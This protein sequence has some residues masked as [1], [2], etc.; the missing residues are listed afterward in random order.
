MIR[1]APSAAA[2]IDDAIAVSFDR[3]ESRAASLGTSATALVRAARRASDGGK[4]FRPALV[5]ASF[6]AFGGDTA[7]TPAIWQVAAA[8]EILHTAFVIHDDVIDRDTE[9]RG[10]LNVVGEFRERGRE[11]GA[12]QAGAAQLGEAAAILAGDLLLHEASRIIATAAL[13]PLQRVE[14]FGLLDDAILVSAVGELTDVEHAI[15]AD[16]PDTDQLLG[17]AHDKTAVYSFRAP[18]AAGALLA[19]AS[20]DARQAL[21]AAGAQIGLAFQLV[22]D[23]IGTFG[24]VSQAGKESGADLRETKRTP[25]IALARESDSWPV[26]STALALAPTGPIAVRRAQKVLNASGARARLVSLVDHTLRSARHEGQSALPQPAVDL[27]AELS[28]AVERRIP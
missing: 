11:S 19:G 12:D 26:V 1:L 10:V 8:M 17:T 27:L 3:L 9:R 18:M 24:T 13:T 16:D 25:L 2:A 14:L 22:D 21:E 5:V 23:L 15:Q 20:P 6:E 28:D 7:R 4:R